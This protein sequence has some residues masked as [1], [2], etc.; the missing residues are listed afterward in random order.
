MWMYE[1]GDIVEWALM[2][3]DHRYETFLKYKE[4]YEASSTLVWSVE[5]ETR[6]EAIARYHEFMGCEPYEPV[7]DK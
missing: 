7:S 2:P 1:E 4:K 3:V 5:T 6:D